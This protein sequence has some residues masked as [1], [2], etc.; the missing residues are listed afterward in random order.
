MS[1]E[2]LQTFQPFTLKIASQTRILLKNALISDQL[3]QVV[4]V[5]CEFFTN[6][7][8]LLEQQVYWVKNMMHLREK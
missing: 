5:F 7:S 4:S 8:R 2:R 3:H 6:I 1:R